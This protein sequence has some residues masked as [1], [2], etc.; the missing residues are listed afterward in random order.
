MEHSTSTL[1]GRRTAQERPTALG[2]RQ[3]IHR[4]SSQPAR[5]L[6]MRRH[7]PPPDSTMSKHPILLATI[8][9]VWC[10]TA[11]AQPTVIPRLSRAPQDA[12]QTFRIVQNYLSDPAHGLFTVVR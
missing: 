2:D 10:S 9:A 8:V 4:S 1:S 3:L 7:F 12:E 6:Q 11:A 5:A